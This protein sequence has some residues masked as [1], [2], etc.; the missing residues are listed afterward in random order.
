MA[1]KVVW[2]LPVKYMLPVYAF[3]FL[4]LLSSTFAYDHFELF[5]IKQGTG[6]DVMKMIG[7]GLDGGF[8]HRAHY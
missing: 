4:W 2:D 3:G 1:D 8:C 5:G 6:V 7:L